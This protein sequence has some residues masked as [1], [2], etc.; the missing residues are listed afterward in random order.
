MKSVVKDLELIGYSSGQINQIVKGLD[1]GY[2]MSTIFGIE[3]DIEDMREFRKAVLKVDKK[4]I[5]YGLTLEINISDCI[6]ENRNYC[7]TKLYIDLKSKKIDPNKYLDENINY[8]KNQC[9]KLNEIIMNKNYRDERIFYDNKLRTKDYFF[10]KKMLNKELPINNYYEKGYSV[11]QIEVIEN[12]T[13]SWIDLT[14]YCNPKD[15]IEKMKFIG[16][17]LYEIR[18]SDIKI[19]EELFISLIKRGY[20]LGQLKELYFALNADIDITKMLDIRLNR[21]QMSVIGKGIFDEIDITCYADVNYSAQQ[22]DMIRILET[23]IE[24]DRANKLHNEKIC[25]IGIITNKEYDVEEM[26]EIINLYNKLINSL[27]APITININKLFKEKS[28]KEIS[29]ILSN[30]EKN[31]YEEER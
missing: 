21:H 11:K 19:P 6:K 30:K 20:N 16:D 15:D 28:L 31:S 7:T 1:N 5:D 12:Y 25:D 18:K 4:L 2:D 26:K 3:T 29:E 24:K 8:N 27:K 10:I 23:K 13:H 17:T 9:K 14:T 22:M